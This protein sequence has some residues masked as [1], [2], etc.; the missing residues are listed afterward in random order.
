MKFPDSCLI[1]N[2]PP[3]FNGWVPGWVGILALV[4]LFIPATLISGAYS[5]NITEMSSGMGILSEHIMFANFAA[6]CGLMIAGP[7]VFHIVRTYRFR[8]M[9]LCGFALLMLLS[10]ICTLTETTAL[11]VL[12]NFLMGGVRIIVILSIIF[13]LA[14]GVMAVNVGYI[15]TPPKEISREQVIEMNNN[16][17]GSLNLIYMLFLSIGQLGNYI[18]SYVAY[19]YR[20]QYSYLVVMGMTIIAMLLV[21]LLLAPG[22]ERPGRQQLVLPPI[23]QAIPCALVFISISYILTYGK[24]YDWFDDVRISVASCIG[25][26][27]LGIFILQQAVSERHLID[28]NALRRRGVVFAV[29]GFFLALFLASSSAL[30][31]AIMGLGVKLDTIQ[32]AGIA[33]WQFLGI[34]LGAITNVLMIKRQFHAR[35]ICAVAFSLITISAVLLYFRFQT[36]IE[37]SQVY[38]P[39]VLRTMGMFM[40]YAF[41]GYYGILKLQDADRQI[42]TWIFLMLAFR[43]VLGPVTGAA[44]YSNAIYHRTQHYIERFAVE[45]DVASEAATTFNRTRMGLMMQG[46]SSNEATQIASLSSKGNIQIQATLVALKEISGWT[47]WLGIGCVGFVL[48]F[49]YKERALKLEKIDKTIMAH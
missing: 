2:N 30:V 29:I 24:T 28:F 33:K 48:L 17:G 32:S 38:L 31:S 1:K 3:L 8:D 20:W 40:L 4:L 43:T 49:P 41:C 21:L 23:S 35:W 10:G 44:V 5:N 19:H 34:I 42:G 46:K 39:T 37:F 22:R 13:C 26:I 45:S 25:V 12:C 11:I 6:S 18:T 27:S 15:L 9:L 36:M 14:E 47:I 7:F 16:R